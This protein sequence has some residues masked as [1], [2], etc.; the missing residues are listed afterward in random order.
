MVKGVDVMKTVKK[1][2][3]VEVT[4]N[5]VCEEHRIVGCRKCWPVEEVV[6][7]VEAIVAAPPVDANNLVACVWL[8]Y[9]LDIITRI[10][11][12]DFLNLIKEGKWPVDILKYLQEE[13]KKIG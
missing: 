9:K 1:V 4:P 6:K 7:A 12:R 8:M 10:Q 3:A 2:V 5:S 11:V 13:V